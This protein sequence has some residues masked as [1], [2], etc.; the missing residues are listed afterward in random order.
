MRGCARKTPFSTQRSKRSEAATVNRVCGNKFSV[1]P[2]EAVDVKLFDMVLCLS[3]AIDFLHPRISEHHLRVAY[4]GAC[5]A[6]ELG[7]AAGPTQ[8]VLIAGALHDVAAVTSSMRHD[9]F[10]KALT[11]RHSGN[12]HLPDDLH[13]HGFDAYRMLCDFSPFA[14]AACAI[15]FHHV[16]WNFGEGNAFRGEPVPFA[17]HILRLA[18]LVAVLPSHDQSILEQVGALR[19]KINAGTGSMF[20]PRIVAAFGEIA[21]KESFWFDLTSRHKE[22]IIRRRFGVAQVRL[23]LDGLHNLSRIFGRIIDC[24]SPFTATHSSGVA[25]TSEAFAIRLGMSPSQTRLIG[26]AGYLHDI[27]K[28]AVPSTIL[29]KPGK[30]TAAEMLVIKQHPYHTHQILA[31]VPGLETVNTWAS[32]HHERLD[33]KGYPFRPRAIPLGSRI[34]AVADIF[35]AITEDR[36]YRNGMERTQCLSI[37]DNL[38]AEGAIDG[39]IV[40]VLHNDF[41]KIHHI[42]SRSQQANANQYHRDDTALS[43]NHHRDHTGYAGSAAG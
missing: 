42:R 21:A 7:L 41:D 18:D 29:D 10:E 27:G 33:A 4:I 26:V 30:L 23:D 39:D 38:V 20:H 25:A 37:L 43:S 32:L 12:A 16:D 1:M 24:R 15:R 9:L 6:E 5:L 14:L 19:K 36:P 34:I 35:T 2:S 11:D 3:R 40:A 31:M 13:R 17:S 28:L 22:E 8:D